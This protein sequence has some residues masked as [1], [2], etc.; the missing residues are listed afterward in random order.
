MSSSETTSIVMDGIL[1]AWY[2]A[3]VMGHGT[4]DEVMQRFNRAKEIHPTIAAE[5][6]KRLEAMRAIHPDRCF[7]TATHRN[8]LEKV[9]NEQS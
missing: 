8:F 2:A 7:I 6:Q 4:R 5:A 1:E 3:H 9:L